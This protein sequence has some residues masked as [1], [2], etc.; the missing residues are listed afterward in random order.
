MRFREDPGKKRADWPRERQSRRVHA[1]GLWVVSK[2]DSPGRRGSVDLP[3]HVRRH[4]QIDVLHRVRDVSFRADASRIRTGERTP[5]NSRPTKRIGQPARNPRHRR[6]RRSTRPQRPQNSRIRKPLD[7]KPELAETAQVAA[8]RR[9]GQRA[10]SRTGR[11]L[12]PG[13]RHASVRNEH[14]RC[15][16]RCLP[17]EGGVQ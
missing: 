9:R 5:R 6:H 4:R 13:S 15:S 17:R 16:K 7:T 3:A 1:R 14:A 2:V 12:R 11:R 8:A 10:A